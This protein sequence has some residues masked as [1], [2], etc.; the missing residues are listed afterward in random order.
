VLPATAANPQQL[1]RVAARAARRLERFL[2]GQAYLVAAQ[3]MADRLLPERPQNGLSSLAELREWHRQRG[4][5][6]LFYAQ[7]P[8]EALP[9]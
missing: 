7:F 6:Q 3:E 4:T 5:L 9:R 8:D 2:V 1:F